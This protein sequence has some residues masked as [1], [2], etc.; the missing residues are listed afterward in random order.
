M[1][2]P[3]R[4]LAI[5]HLLALSACAAG[6]TSAL[7][8]RP[9]QPFES[10]QEWAEYQARLRREGERLSRGAP[11]PQM[12]IEPPFMH[13]PPPV[14][15]VPGQPPSPPPPA[16]PVSTR[17][18]PAAEV[19]RG[20][21]VRVHGD[22][23]VALHRGRLFTVRIGGQALEPVSM[24]DAFE[25]RAYRAF[26]EYD[27]LLIWG[28]RVVTVALGTVTSGGVEL[29]V[30]QLG[31]DGAL[32]RRAT[33]TLASR[34]GHFNDW[35]MHFTR[36]VGDRLVFYSDLAPNDLERLA[37]FD[38]F[39]AIR[40]A[41][42]DRFVPLAPDAPTRIHR[43]AAGNTGRD[44]HTVT[45]CALVDDD[46]R[47][48]STALYGPQGRPV[49]LSGTAVYLWTRRQDRHWDENEVPRDV[50]YRLPFDGS[51][52]RALRVAGHPV[53]AFSFHESDGHI[54]VLVR[55]D[56]SGAAMWGQDRGLALLRVPLA[57]L[58]DGTGAAS[59]AQYRPL[60][61]DPA[62]QLRH[63]FVGDWLVY[64]GGASTVVESPGPDATTAYAVHV[65]G[66]EVSAVPVA[67]S[68][69]RIDAA[70]SRVVIL[71][72]SGPDLH[73]TALR[74][75]SAGAAATARHTLPG[76]GEGWRIALG[77]FSGNGEGGDVLALPLQDF[78]GSGGPRPTGTARIALLRDGGSR[79]EP[80]GIVEAKSA[81]R[82]DGCLAD[83]RFWF[84][85]TRPVF[86]GGRVLAL[87]GFE[88]VE[89]DLADGGLREGRRVDL[90]PRPPTETLA[91]D[92]AFTERLGPEAGPYRCRNTG[93]MRLERNGQALA[94][95][96][97]QTGECI[98]NDVAGAS[99]GE[100]SGTGIITRGTAFTVAVNGCTY[101][102]RMLGADAFMGN[103]SCP[104]TQPGRA[105][106]NVEGSLEAH[107]IQ[108]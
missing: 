38:A 95:R 101:I 73:V 8:D 6:G 59:A 46:L 58:G 37:S 14:P 98:V 90:A 96:Y 82:D 22:F 47:C 97:R 31:R 61:P 91:G 1:I 75:D 27:D 12:I 104:V 4:L 40:R 60:P 19:D 94:L 64:G 23:L 44:M 68:V 74:L 93:T 72:A 78:T 41:D 63:R 81:E 89:A 67:H 49:Y 54:N 85:N 18:Q 92:W 106:R 84:D 2:R 53:D 69:D 51:A 66:G 13:P 103:V 50:L 17:V 83:C 65:A 56:A 71:G 88:V 35:R 80:L 52:P 100:G 62:G 108:P 45:S 25:P 5:A 26:H 105:R 15:Q 33:Y 102:L 77:A 43:P 76:P 70:G 86:A 36:L 107:R 79:L 9:L 10:E 57:Q 99:D 39:P 48:R 34:G 29:G 7:R 20:P 28:D 21:L 24:V 11:P 87:M 55:K 42:G 30:F 32:S 3:P 16:V